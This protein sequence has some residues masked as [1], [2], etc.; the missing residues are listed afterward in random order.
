MTDKLRH[1]AEHLFSD[2]VDNSGNYGTRWGKESL[3]KINEALQSAFNAGA[4]AMR[5]EISKTIPFGCKCAADIR[6]L[7]LPAYE[8]Q[9]EKNQ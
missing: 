3:Y 4:E 8:N 1:D 2:I 7:S 6:A 5:A 9:K